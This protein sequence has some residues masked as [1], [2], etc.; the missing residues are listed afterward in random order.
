VTHDD[1]LLALGK[2]IGCPVWI[3]L[4]QP[5]VDG[6]FAT[7]NGI[8]SRGVKR[9]HPD[10]IFG[11]KFGVVPDGSTL[12]EVGVPATRASFRVLDPCDGEWVAEGELLKITARGVPEVWVRRM[13]SVDVKYAAYE[14]VTPVDA[15]G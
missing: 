8:L 13:S 9:G 5:G 3:I 1:T 7:F 6:P 14:R 11:T 15:E 2:L 10:P 12:F 4:S